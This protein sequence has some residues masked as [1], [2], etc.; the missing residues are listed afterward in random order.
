MLKTF[1]RTY[2]SSN[3]GFSKYYF[4]GIGALVVIIVVAAAAIFLS[5]DLQKNLN[6]DQGE[7]LEKSRVAGEIVEIDYD[8]EYFVIEDE[9][10]GEL[11]KVNLPEGSQISAGGVTGG[12]YALG[13][14]KEGQ[15]IELIDVTYKPGKK[16]SGGGS[17]S[18]KNGSPDNNSGDSG[19]D[20]DEDP[21]DVDDWEDIY[22]YFPYPAFPSTILSVDIENRIIEVEAVISK[23][24]RFTVNINSDTTISS[25]D[26]NFV[27]SIVKF[28]E[29]KVGWIVDVFPEED[30]SE[31][32]VLNAVVIMVA[33]VN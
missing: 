25:R 33:K 15:Y 2:L 23:G 1:Y 5:P 12:T 31:N 21:N 9:Q 27:K 10:S 17:D 6:I 32:S 11:F 20:S 26:P 16:K 30:P 14:L 22:V 28:S 8:A 4:I 29:L 13:D 24:K 18:K 3:A 19:D 7:K